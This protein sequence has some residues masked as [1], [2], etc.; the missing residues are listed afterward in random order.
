MFGQLGNGRFGEGVASDVPA[1]VGSD[2]DWTRV[3]AND[4]RSFAL[5]ADQSIWGGATTRAAHSESLRDRGIGCD[6]H[7]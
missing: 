2:H 4:G 3:V 5:K 1:K 7:R 6:R